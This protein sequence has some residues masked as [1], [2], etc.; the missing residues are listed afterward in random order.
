MSLFSSLRR[1]QKESIGLLQIGT[2]LEYF[3]LMLYVHMAVLLNELFFPKSDPHT[4]TLLSAFAFCSTW[5][6]RPFGALLFGWIGDNIGR[7]PTVVITTMMMA[8]SCLIMANL[9]TYEQIG[10]AAAWIVTLCRVTQG[11]S[12]M[13]ERIGAEI[14]IVEI[15][16][17]PAQ[18]PAV[19]LCSVFAT[20]GAVFALAIASLVT[21]AGFDWR[22][23]FWFGVCIA[24]VGSVARTRLR[25]TPDFVNM[26]GRIKKA[27]ED[28]SHDGLAKAAELLK[29]TNILWKEKV[30]KKTSLSSL[31][32]NL[33]WPVFFFFVYVYCGDILKNK[34]GF[35]SAQ[36]IQNNF[37][38]SVV[39]LI[40]FTLWMY[41]SYRIHPLRILKWKLLPAFILILFIPSFLH[42]NDSAFNLFLLQSVVIFLAP[43][44]MPAESI[45]IKHFPIFKRFTYATFIYALSRAL[46]YIIT[47]FGL[48]Y[49]TIFFGTYGLFI[50][51]IPTCI[52]YLYGLNHFEKLE[53]EFADQP[54]RTDHPFSMEPL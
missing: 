8:L 13:G 52:G 3:D 9:P 12:S 18:Y 23:A 51:F 5:I 54:P 47:S 45:L 16:K 39:Q 50:I 4:A 36:I 49:L 11:L 21:V 30:N 35:T 43:D 42:Y 6:L 27:I 46:M 19:A 29:S 7:K 24:L 53:E 1:D 25:E 44:S 41:L 10:I 40:G 28:S 33:S 26:K 34:F 15:T 48:V 38:V 2:F 20:L 22:F 17:P 31:L 14:Y 37:Y 32:I